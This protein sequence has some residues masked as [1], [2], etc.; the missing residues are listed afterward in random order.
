MI[1]VGYRL[2]SVVPR[3]KRKETKCVA[4]SASSLASDKLAAADASDIALRQRAESDERL[5]RQIAAR[6]EAARREKVHREAARQAAAEQ[7]RRAQRKAGSVWHPSRTPSPDALPTLLHGVA[8]SD[9]NDPHVANGFAPVR[10]PPIPPSGPVVVQTQRVKAQASRPTA[11]AFAPPPSDEVPTPPGNG[12]PQA[13]GLEPVAPLG[14]SRGSMTSIGGHGPPPRCRCR[15]RPC[16]TGAARAVPRRPAAAPRPAGRPSG[17]RRIVATS[18]AQHRRERHR[19]AAAARAA[20][21]ACAGHGAVGPRSERDAG[22][23][24]NMLRGSGEESRR[25]PSAASWG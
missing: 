5:R 25:R 2:S 11:S 8:V 17:G 12:C 22:R 1:Y 20:T 24:P 10:A 23:V 3:H 18:L 19:A 7:A 14:G 6:Q 4:S 21:A 15:R 9:E 13:H 16:G